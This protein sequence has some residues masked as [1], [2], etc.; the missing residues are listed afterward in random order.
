[1]GTLNRFDLSNFS[2]SGIWHLGNDTNL[3]IDWGRE[4]RG[5]PMLGSYNGLDYLFLLT[6]TGGDFNQGT[7]LAMAIPE[8]ST[9]VVVLGGML[10]LFTVRKRL[11]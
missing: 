2:M 3:G 9:A 7:L 10:L 4:S 11:G 5:G 8:P 1:G 6:R